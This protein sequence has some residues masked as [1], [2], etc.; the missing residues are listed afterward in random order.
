MIEILEQL[1]RSIAN[2][3]PDLELKMKRAGIYDTPMAFIKKTMIIALYMNI[4]IALII[5]MLI[6]K[7]GLLWM[8]LII[9]PIVQVILFT[10]FMHLPDV[11]I[12]KKEKA[13]N[14]EIVFAG[15]FIIIEISSGVSLYDTMKSVADH[16]V[17]VGKYFKNILQKVDI[18]TSL[19]DALNE[20][21]ELIP[22]NNL[23]RIMWQII[24]SMKTGS[25][26]ATSLRI[27]LEQ[28]SKE[29]FIEIQK[30]GRKL[31]PLAMFYMMI[32]V[33]IPSLGVTML[34]I[35]ASFID[36]EI[37]LG[38]LMVVVGGLSF[39]QFMFLSMIKSSRPAVEL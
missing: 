21:V 4:G 1:F 32:A 33:I 12:L 9:F 26:M 13:I 35:L 34:V 3:F 7:K 16:Y 31:N 5:F 36:L 38:I 2:A 11:K 10:Y 39:I 24:N 17:H 30:Y 20:E 15:R 14:K 19:E 29:Q 18:G 8:L 28:I 37:G 6:A 27:V 22:S 25:D 23:K